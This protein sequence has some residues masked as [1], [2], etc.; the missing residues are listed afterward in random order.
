MMLSSSLL[1]RS[2]RVVPTVQL[3]TRALA[4]TAQS[5]TS[6]VRLLWQRF[7]VTQTR[8]KQIRSL[9]CK[10]ISMYMYSYIRSLIN[11]IMWKKC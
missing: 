3:A 1:R 5:Q 7:C 8:I 2:Y 11:L 9:C 6:A 10:T 4:G